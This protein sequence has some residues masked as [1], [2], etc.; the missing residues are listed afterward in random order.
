MRKIQTSLLLILLLLFTTTVNA[1]IVFRGDKDGLTQIY[2]M[3]DDGGNI[4]P[5]NNN[6]YSEWMPRWSPNGRRIVF[7][8]DTTPNDQRGNPDIYIMNADGSHPQ[9]LLDHKHTIRDMMISPDGKRLIYITGYIGLN[10][11]DIDSRNSET[12]LTSHGYHCDWS[13]DGN[14][15]VYVNDDH[16]IIEKNLWLVDINGFNPFAWTHP[17]PDKGA[18]HRFNPR[19]SSYGG[20]MLYTEMDLV[21]NQLRPAGTFRVIIHNIRDDTTQTLKIPDNW[22]ISSVA[23]MDEDQSV[24]FSAYEYIPNNNRGVTRKIYKY[25]L[26]SHEY[27][28]LAEGS[29]AHWNGGALSVSPADKQSVRWAELKKAYTVK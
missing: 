6:P 2:I 27:T 19:W 5:I 12:I 20:H 4:T 18:M 17:D 24:L 25:D 10:I 29:D 16:D 1:K 13:P 21:V 14:R 28:F 22:N 9:Q 8:R 23:W 3:D 7:L 11:L 15:I 26:A